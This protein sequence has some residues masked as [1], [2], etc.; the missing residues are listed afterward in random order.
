MRES[1]TM[2]NA[3]LGRNMVEDPIASDSEMRSG[4][5]TLK[6]LQEDRE[7]GRV[8]VLAGLDHVPTAEAGMTD[9]TTTTAMGL[10]FVME[11]IELAIE[12][13]V[14]AGAGVGVGTTEAEAVAEAAAA[15][16]TRRH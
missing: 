7:K 6:K 13:R 12:A 9:M 15:T 14:E 3:A 5:V 16:D 2:K 4:R 1:G 8:G 11:A 10:A